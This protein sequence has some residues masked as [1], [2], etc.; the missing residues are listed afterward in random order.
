M[1]FE[2]RAPRR[3]CTGDEEGSP[4][5]PRFLAWSSWELLQG[6]RCL[7]ITSLRSS[8][9]HLKQE[10]AHSLEAPTQQSWERTMLKENKI[11]LLLQTL[12]SKKKQLSNFW[13]GS[14]MLSILGKAPHPPS[15]G[16]GL[17]QVHGK[18]IIEKIPELYD[19]ENIL[20]QA[21]TTQVEGAFS[22]QSQFPPL[23]YQEQIISWLPWM[24]MFSKLPLF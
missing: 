4:E 23:N 10:P 22:H 1:R 18:S 12:K 3:V 17:V 24:S 13:F 11:K 7:T 5:S 16:S 6:A 9:S 8:G 19:N 15:Q 20:P 21:S 2:Q 14:L